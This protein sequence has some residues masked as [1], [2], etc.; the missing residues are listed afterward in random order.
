MLAHL[1]IFSALGLVAFGGLA[2]AFGLATR[3]AM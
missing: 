2:Y 1:D 3:S